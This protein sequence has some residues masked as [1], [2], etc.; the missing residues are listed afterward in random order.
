MQKATSY[1]GMVSSV[2]GKCMRW[3]EGGVRRPQTEDRRGEPS[4]KAG[5]SVAKMAPPHGRQCNDVR[6]SVPTGCRGVERRTGQPLFKNLS[7]QQ[8]PLPLELTLQRQGDDTCP[9]QFLDLEL[10]QGVQ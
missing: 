9:R 3:H 7:F 10:P 6:E 4:R 5:P 8:V 2:A 1:G